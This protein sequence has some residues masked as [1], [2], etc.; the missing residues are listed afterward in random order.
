LESEAPPRT[1][2]PCHQG[3]E[4]RQ[5]GILILLDETGSMQQL[6]GIDPV[7][8]WGRGQ[9]IVIEKFNQFIAILQNQV[10]AGE[11]PDTE[12]TLITFNKVAKVVEYPSIL[13]M[14]PITTEDYNPGYSTN[15][16][17]SLGCALSE[18]V[19]IHQGPAAKV[20]IISDGIHQPG[21]NVKV[22][23]SDHEIHQMVSK[24]RADE[25]WEFSF[26]GAMN[27]EDKA[28]L[29][30]EAMNLGI[31]WSETKKFDF[32]T[33]SID[34]ILKSISSSLKTGAENYEYKSVLE[35]QLTNRCPK[36]RFGK[37]CRQGKKTG[38][39]AT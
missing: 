34:I 19:H 15:L 37:L 38:K 7:T 21:R 3:N 4:D 29:K 9:G 39:A 2:V 36:G 5:P 17:D 26:F 20:F 32:T 22:A 23:W 30:H 6:G 18:Y 8:N 12:F 16:Y 13:E 14:Q 28:H 33:N 35:R 25:D 31:R 10:R 27:P 24:L 1:E 11:T